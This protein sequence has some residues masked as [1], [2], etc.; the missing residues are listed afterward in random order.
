MRSPKGALADQQG[1]LAICDDRALMLAIFAERGGSAA[2]Q[3]DKR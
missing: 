2:G 1:R 3:E